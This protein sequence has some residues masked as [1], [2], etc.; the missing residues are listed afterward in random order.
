MLL[1]SLL[2]QLPFDIRLYILDFIRMG[3]KYVGP[4]TPASTF[5][6]RFRDD[7]TRKAYWMFRCVDLCPLVLMQKSDTCKF[8]GHSEIVSIYLSDVFEDKQNDAH[9]WLAN[10][11]RNHRPLDA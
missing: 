2:P 9:L 6:G 5:F 4:R 3:V 7:S 10:M 8:F 1:Y 11:I